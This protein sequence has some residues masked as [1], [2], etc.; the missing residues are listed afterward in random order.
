M[1]DGLR[2]FSATRR[3]HLNIYS[4]IYT[5]IND[6]VLVAN[7]ERL[8]YEYYKSGQILVLS[9]SANTYKEKRQDTTGYNCPGP[10]THRHSGR[11]YTLE[12]VIARSKRHFDI[13]SSV[14]DTWP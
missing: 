8:I 5:G 4:L 14:L 12:L 3:L 7:P 1:K 6:G 13:V 10:I 2:Y 11:G 9:T